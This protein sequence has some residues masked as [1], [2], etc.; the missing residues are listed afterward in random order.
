[1]VRPRKDSA[2]LRP[3]SYGHTPA[4][5]PG[6]KGDG[7]GSAK[8]KFMRK[9][10]IV[11]ADDLESRVAILEDG[12]LAELHVERELRMVGS[13]YKARVVSVLPGMDAAFADVGLPKNV[14]LCAD[15][16]GFVSR[17][18]VTSGGAPRSLTISERVKENQEV[19]VQIVRAPV[20][21]K[22][23]RATTRLALPG[24]YLV[25]LLSDGRQVGI[26]RK[27]EDRK[28]RERLRKIGDKIRPNGMGMIVRT[29]AETRGAKEL[30][31]DLKVLLDLRQRIL[32]K[33]EHTRAPALIHQDLTL[34]YQVIRDVFTD[35]VKSLLIDSKSAHDNAVELVEAIAPE[36]RKRVKRYRGKLPIFQKH[37][38][39]GEIDRLLRRRVWL[40]AGGYISIDQAE[41]FTAI[42]VNTGRY[43]GSTGL[44]DTI[45][46][47]NL[48]AAEVVARQLR[49]RDLGGII[50]IDFIDMDRPGHR[51]RVMKAFEEELKRDRQKTKILHLS[52]LGLI[53]MTRK[54]RG[55]S[56]LGILM[57]TCPHCAGLGRIRNSLTVALKIE[58]EVRRIAA[59]DKKQA[60][61]V[62]AAPRVAAVI[63]GDD[64][65]RAAAL[66]KAT[67]SAIYLRGDE[68]MPVEDQEIAPTTL[69][70]VAR[71]LKLH[72]KGDEVVVDHLDPRD[73][74]SPDETYGWSEGYR[75]L[76]EGA[77]PGPEPQTVV[78]SEAGHSFGKGRV[79]G[80]ETP[81]EPK[82]PSRRGRGRGRGRR[83]AEVTLA[84]EPELAPVEAALAPPTGPELATPAEM[85]LTEMAPAEQAPER[86]RRRRGGRGRGRR[87]PEAVSEPEPQPVET[88]VVP[89]AELEPGIGPA[90]EPA[91]ERPR[92]RRGGRG[93]GRRR[94]EAVTETE[95]KPAEVAV[96]PPVEPEPEATP[97]AEPA[98][99]RPRRRRGG[100]RRGGRRKPETQATEAE[101]PPAAALEPPAAAS[102]DAA[103]E[104]P[105]PARR[106]SL[107]RRGA[108][109]KTVA[110]TVPEAPARVEP[111]PPP[112]AEP[113]APPRRGLLRRGARTIGGR[114]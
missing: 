97:A 54:R 24:R 112:A 71:D 82:G 113:A 84:P 48:E 95:P 78:L 20:A 53:E 93:R 96:T 98:P 111:T 114:R 35:D 92:R 25:L 26:S 14:F 60:I 62:R 56:L 22:G 6:E 75:V 81:E 69:A 7:H 73:P 55:E 15:D 101:S 59:E 61:I 38:I 51:Q 5:K 31:A 49:L 68:R 104:Q 37:G 72:H 70:H 21:S 74:S 11:N 110:A 33:A 57:E 23:A 94:P 8:T 3:K 1:M 91:P 50:V 65:E 67:G 66:E 10:I 17:D 13:I 29:E 108:R 32:A 85:T 52:P 77:I 40:K 18:G 41:A 103:S 99:E 102:Q 27:I 63:I 19:V 83:R 16:V 105:T 80:V 12:Q 43:T 58:R 42:D 89:P 9:E 47:T 88:A 64:G 109:S 30:E 36:L 86:P 28:E 4:E 76:I 90:A 100:S 34:T 45:L 44:A 106:T 46:R 2:C 87:A 39:E 79:Q 107:L